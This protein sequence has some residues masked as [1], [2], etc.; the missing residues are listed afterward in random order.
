M[1]INSAKDLK[2]IFKIH[3]TQKIRGKMIYTNRN[4]DRKNNLQNL[5]SQS[6]E[7]YLFSEKFLSKNLN[8]K[9]KLK[10]S[11]D[12]PSKISIII[13]P[14]RTNSINKHQLDLVQKNKYN[15]EH[16]SKKNTPSNEY[17]NLNE[18]GKNINKPTKQILSLNKR[19]KREKNTKINY[20]NISKSK[21]VKNGDNKFNLVN[22][23]NKE[24]K[25]LRC[26]VLVP[27]QQTIKIF[28]IQ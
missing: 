20:L 9:N 13:K 14:N 19:I 26:K 1:N 17:K 7:N 23:E 12:T 8:E 24:L 15:H 18:K 4:N 11:N 16:L 21:V 5:S 27:N 25:N 2:D 22:Q 28:K 10:K 6:S 3:N